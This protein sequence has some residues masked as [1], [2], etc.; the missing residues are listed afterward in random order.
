M[1]LASRHGGDGRIGLL[2]VDEE[3]VDEVGRG[4]DIFANHG[5]DTG[6][7]SVTT[8]SGALFDPYSSVVVAG[9]GGRVA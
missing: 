5:A 9:D 8:G 7:L 2:R 1:A 4:D 3:G 6:G